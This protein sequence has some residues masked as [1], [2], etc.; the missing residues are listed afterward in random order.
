M[1]NEY[2]NVTIAGMTFEVPVYESPQRTR[3]LARDV[4][5]RFRRIEAA[6]KKVNTQMF[7]L[8]TAMSYAVDLASARTDN[9]D[10]DKEMVKALSEIVTRLRTR[11]RTEE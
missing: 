4:E 11:A 3:E 8:Q 9:H 7:A 2:V 10:Q 5:A 6:H 1:S